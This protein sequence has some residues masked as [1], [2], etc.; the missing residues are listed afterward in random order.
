M[1][2]PSRCARW[3]SRP[4]SIGV[5]HTESST[6]A[7]SKCGLRIPHRFHF[8]NRER[9]AAS[10]RSGSRPLR[11]MAIG[12]MPALAH[13]VRIARSASVHGRRPP[14]R[15]LLS[16]TV[17][18]RRLDGRRHPH[19][20]AVRTPPARHALAAR[21]RHGRRVVATARR[22]RPTTSRASS[23]LMPAP[24]ND[25]TARASVATSADRGIVSVTPTPS[26]SLNW[27]AMS[28]ASGSTVPT[29]S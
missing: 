1:E 22:H 8:D 11:Q 9:I 14:V 28:V 7:P 5:T 25:C 20:P 4:R 16:C 12:D 18:H 26:A 27:S 10:D 3:R 6:R 23:T 29:V 19:E 2:I 17:P 13:S 15:H 24:V 21:P